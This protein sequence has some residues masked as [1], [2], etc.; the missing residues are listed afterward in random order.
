MIL[1]THSWGFKLVFDV[2]VDITEATEME[3]RYKKPSKETGVWDAALDDST[4][5]FYVIK[6][7]DLDIQGLWQFQAFI[8]TSDW[9]IPGEVIHVVVTNKI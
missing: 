1:Y 4:S 8:T 2:E 7:G 9:S 3:I 6:E 5:I